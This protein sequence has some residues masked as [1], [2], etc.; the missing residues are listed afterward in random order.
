MH[1]HGIIIEKIQASRNDDRYATC[2]AVACGRRRERVDGY[3]R[4]SA[5]EQSGFRVE[6]NLDCID[7]SVRA[8]M[9]AE[10]EVEGIRRR[11]IWI[12]RC[13]GNKGRRDLSGRTHE[14]IRRRINGCELLVAPCL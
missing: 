9:F 8:A 12:G 2:G 10:L 3:T 4:Q 1:P 14:Q 7:T 5:M 6:A 11:K 13:H